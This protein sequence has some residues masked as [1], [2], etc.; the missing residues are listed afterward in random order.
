MRWT[1]GL[2][3]QNQ[4]Q[5]LCAQDSGAL[6]FPRRRL[7]LRSWD[8]WVTDTGGGSPRAAQIQVR[9]SALSRGGLGSFLL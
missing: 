7:S 5:D 1:G 6:S 8:A 2:W 4:V 9:A 3:Q